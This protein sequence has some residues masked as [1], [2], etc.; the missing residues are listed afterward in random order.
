MSAVK[1]HCSTEFGYPLQKLNLSQY[2]IKV[3]NINQLAIRDSL[4]L[5]LSH[6][7]QFAVLLDDTHFLY[8]YLHFAPQYTWA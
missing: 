3:P 7:K 4:Y 2:S 8:M 5:V 1:V 6:F